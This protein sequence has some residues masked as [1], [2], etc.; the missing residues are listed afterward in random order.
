MLWKPRAF[1]RKCLRLKCHQEGKCL[2]IDGYILKW[3]MEHRDQ[4]LCFKVSAKYLARTSLIDMH[5]L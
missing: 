4:D 1:G 5:L 3:M 2:G